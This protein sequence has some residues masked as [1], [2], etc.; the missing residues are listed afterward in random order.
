M[1][2][3]SCVLAGLALLAGG[4]APAW[5]QVAE[6]DGGLPR[7]GWLGAAVQFTA[8]PVAGGKV[9][10]I[11]DGSAAQK[12]GLHVGDIVT[13]IDGRRLDSARNAAEMVRLLPAE[14]AATF[15]VDRGGQ[16]L[17]LRG[18]VPEA[19]RETYANADVIYTSVT[20]AKGEKLRMIVTRPKGVT[21]RLPVILVATWLSEDSVEAPTAATRDGSKLVL[22]GLADTRDY[23]LVRVDK[24]GVGDSEGVC[25]ETDFATELSGCRAAFRRLGDFD[26]ID[27]ERIFIFGLSNGGGYA[28]LVADGAP[29]RGFI[30]EG[31]WC[32]TWYEHMLEIER[33]RFTL[34]GWTPAEVSRA[35]S[36]VAELYTDYL[37]HGRAPADIFA[38]KPALREFW[39]DDTPDVQ[40]GRPPAFYQQ[41]QKL[42]LA[43]AWSQVRAPTLALHGE[44]DWIMSR[45]DM[46]LIAELVNRNSPGAA[47]FRA[48]P[49]RGH[50]FPNFANMAEAFNWSAAPF[51]GSIIPQLKAW[52]AQHR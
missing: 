5:A 2:R 48:L 38:A 47:E 11:L 7:R 43:A 41:L 8:G 6:N 46:E 18:L 15:A 3:L 12:L 36:G 24:P 19:P 44:F 34:M 27:P 40:Y 42:N 29:V 1:R 32:K 14:R 16:A 35:M 4:F 10:S 28:P 23:V 33:R 9:V 20:D 49:G 45:A 13:A 30:V 22:R 51:D 31:G 50:D 52:L 25:A 37:I 17:T 26:F 21:G 39:T